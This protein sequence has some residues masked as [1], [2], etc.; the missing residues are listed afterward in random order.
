MTDVKP[1]VIAV[2]PCYNT[3]SHIAEVVTKCLPHVDQVIVV[4]D[5]ST[6]DTAEIARKTGALVV[7]HEVRAGAGAATRTGFETALKSKADVL[8]TIDGDGQHDPDDIPLLIAPILKGEADLIIG[9]RFLNK[10]S[11]IPLYRKFG[12]QVINFLYNVGSRLKVSDSQS[13]FRAYSKNSVQSLNIT[14]KGFSFSV[15]L[16]IQARRRGLVIAEVPI[17]CTYDHDSHSLNPIIHGLGVALAIVRLRLKQ[18]ILDLVKGSD[19][20]Q[21]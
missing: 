18:F 4:D 2:I 6:D 10:K 11:N 15:Q 3:E 16:L 21:L 20:S 17:S 13:C 5:E 7:N 14:E 1:K 12:I 9:S 19:G 8:V